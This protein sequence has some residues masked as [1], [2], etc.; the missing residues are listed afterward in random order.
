MRFTHALENKIVDH[1][2][3]GEPFARPA[4]LHVGLSLTEIQD[5]GS[6]VTEPDAEAGYDRVLISN[7]STTW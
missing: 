2:F 3:Y 7:D 6:G 4:Q 1:L 5:D